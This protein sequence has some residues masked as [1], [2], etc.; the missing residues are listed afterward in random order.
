MKKPR[1]PRCDTKLEYHPAAV[2]GAGI[3]RRTSGR[4]VVV[5]WSE[6]LGLII[7]LLGL[8]IPVWNWTPLPLVLVSGGVVAVGAMFVLGREE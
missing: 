8:A 4:R 6:K 2:G 1:C 3:A 7:M 5:K